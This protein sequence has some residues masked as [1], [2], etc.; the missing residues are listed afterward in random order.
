MQ[1]FR[2][3][4]DLPGKGFGFVRCHFRLPSGHSLGEAIMGNFGACPLHNYL[5]K[6]E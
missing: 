1:D 6:V 4:T 3:N 5:E 2:F